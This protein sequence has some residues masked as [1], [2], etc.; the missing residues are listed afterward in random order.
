MSPARSTRERQ[1]GGFE[2]DFRGFYAPAW[3][4]IPARCAFDVTIAQH[5][6]NEGPMIR[7][8]TDAENSG[9][10]HMRK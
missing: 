8:Y 6:R 10:A 1:S 5:L 7:P 2:K 3:N 9:P 4:F